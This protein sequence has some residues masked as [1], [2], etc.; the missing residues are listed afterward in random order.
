MG[1]SGLD[2]KVILENF[3]VREGQLKLT[4]SEA[5]AFADRFVLGERNRFDALRGA[6]EMLGVPQHLWK[7]VIRRWK[8]AGGPPLCEFAPYA[9]H[10]F[11]V[12]MFFVV[13]LAAGL[14]PRP[15][16]SSNRVDIAYLY[17]VPFCM[18]FV[19]GDKLHRMT[20]P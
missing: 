7:E 14:I 13:A 8:S 1:V 18:V 5:K 6:L 15:T 12:D 11:K 3:G 4:L 19:S 10:V 17:Y 16:R 2:P 20:A 9:A